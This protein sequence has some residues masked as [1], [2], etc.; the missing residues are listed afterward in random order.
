MVTV[1]A[2]ILLWF[3]IGV[4]MFKFQVSNPVSEDG[5]RYKERW[6]RGHV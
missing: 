3:P 5:A 2:L 4:Q 1:I 6:F